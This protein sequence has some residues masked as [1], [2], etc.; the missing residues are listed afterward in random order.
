[1]CSAN[2]APESEYDAIGNVTD[3]LVNTRGIAASNSDRSLASGPLLPP[4]NADV[5]VPSNGVPV[6]A[7]PADHGNA[8]GVVSAC[9]A[10]NKAGC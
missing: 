9:V 10:T 7:T 2:V 1:M 3:K 4:R 8:N 6:P 5:H